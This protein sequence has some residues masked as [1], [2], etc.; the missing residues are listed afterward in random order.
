MYNVKSQQQKKKV[1]LITKMKQMCVSVC[2]GEG[3]Q[4]ETNMH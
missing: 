2:V 1:K 4:M 3:S